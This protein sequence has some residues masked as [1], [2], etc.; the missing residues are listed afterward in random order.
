MTRKYTPRSSTRGIQVRTPPGVSFLYRKRYL[1]YLR[2]AG[3]ADKTGE[4]WANVSDAPGIWGKGVSITSSL[5]RLGFVE[6][7]KPHNVLQ[8]RITLAGR[9]ALAGSNLFS[10]MNYKNF[11]LPMDVYEGLQKLAEQLK[12][13]NPREKKGSPTELIRHILAREDAFKRWF[14]HVNAEEK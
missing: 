2:D 3:D 10:T 8:A 13:I 4:G 5:L 9:S 11:Q 14:R 7:R 6:T 1:E 12:M